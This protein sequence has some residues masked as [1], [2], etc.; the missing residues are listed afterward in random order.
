M[1]KINLEN[2]EN[3][4]ERLPVHNLSGSEVMKLIEADGNN[5]RAILML[6]P[7][8]LK[9]QIDGIPVKYI[10]E[11]LFDDANI[12]I[13]CTSDRNLSW[14]SVYRIYRD[15]LRRNDE[16]EV[17]YGREWKHDVV[18]HV[19]SENVF[20]YL[21]SGNNAENIAKKI[22]NDL[23]KK[24]CDP[25]DSRQKVVENVAH[26]ADEKDFDVTLKQLFL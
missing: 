20:A 4:R 23:R 5:E 11:Q 10:I 7:D 13:L 14:R 6:K 8:G 22:K 21:L 18:K 19:A 12:R 3:L 15:V 24:L 1:E 2:E 16:E 17:K 26:V 9:R 25:E